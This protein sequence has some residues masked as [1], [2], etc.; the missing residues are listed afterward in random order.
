[1]ER[2][3]VLVS[4]WMTADEILNELEL[5]DLIEF[6]RPIGSSISYAHWALYIGYFDNA[7]YAVHLSTENSDFGLENKTEIK[8]KMT[9]NGSSAHVRSDS[10]HIIANGSFCRIN[11]SLDAR[12]NPFPPNVI[13][14]RAIFRLG[15][16]GYNIVS[17]NC[18]VFVK[19][20]RYGSAESHQ[21]NV[22]CS[23]LGGFVF[24]A[25]AASLPIGIIGGICSYTVLKNRSKIKA[26][27][28]KVASSFF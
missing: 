28:P 26:A 7:H 1:M 22:V 11:N 10:I 16:C 14:E 3:G 8:S 4:D 6:S 5:G 17:N 9:F 25:A 12:L 15:Q 13:Y 24:G 20:C 23:V 19:E 21:V 27:I 18:E 2:P